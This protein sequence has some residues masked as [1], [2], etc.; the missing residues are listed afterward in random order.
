[1]LKEEALSYYTR[2]YRPG[3]SFD[4]IR[5]KLFDFYNSEEQ[6]N[7]VLLQWQTMKLS[8][9]MKENAQKSEVE[10]FRAFFFKLSTLQKQLSANYQHDNLLRDQ[11]VIACDIDRVQQSLCERVPKTAQEAMNRIAT[12]LSH[13]PRSSSTYVTTS[14][15]ESTALYSLGRR[16]GGEAR[17]SVGFPGQYQRYRRPRR[18]S[19]KWIKGVKGCYVCGQDHK[20]HTRHS[21][22]EV[23]AAIKRL[24][25]SHLSAMLIVEDVA[26][27]SEQLTE[28]PE[29]IDTPD[30]IQFS[31]SDDDDTAYLAADT[32]NLQRDTEVYLANS[33]F[34]HGRTFSTDL[35]SGMAAMFSALSMGEVPRFKGI[36]ID[37]CANRSSVMSYEQYRAYCEEFDAPMN[38]D[39]ASSR[40]VLGIGGTTKAIGTATVPVPFKDLDLVIDVKFQ[41]LKDN[42]PSL[43][44]MKDMKENGL[45]FSIQDEVVR[46]KNAEQDLS[47]EN[48]FLVHRWKSDDLNFALYTESELRK[49]HRVFGHTSVQALYNL[50]KRANPDEMES[51]V[52]KT[53]DKIRRECEV[54]IQNGSKPR[55]FKVTIG[56]D[57]LRFNHIVAVDVMYINSRPVLHIVH[58]GTHFNAAQFLRNMTAQ[59]VWKTLLKC[60]S[61]VYL[62][63]PDFLHVDQGSNFVSAE[64]AA[65]ATADGV[66]V[67][68]APIESPSTMSHV[69]RYHAPLRVAYSKIRDS[70]PRSETNE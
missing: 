44:S 35:K 27:I 30:E 68:E 61:R 36:L 60:W 2:V 70:M 9:A 51:N 57:D 46:F 20:A 33:A 26:Y 69:E 7:R 17:K 34:V 67:L 37:S 31:D 56:T 41:I 50:L 10:V 23:R 66:T 21:P 11:L 12:F 62:G 39:T 42:V 14:A 22:E 64:L 16:Y 48:Y 38:V 55:R 65:N 1:M 32:D 6:R 54:C 8:D 28:V 29:T 13:E 4:G 3:D 63:P 49:L 53:L 47:M 15:G 18:F 43:L 5:E 58:E 19:S 45:D 24:K 25:S 59:H 52:R 40:S